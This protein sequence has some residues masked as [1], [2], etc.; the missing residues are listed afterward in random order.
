M[1]GRENVLE[2]PPHA[3]ITPARAGKS[4][5]GLKNPPS[6]GITPAR[7]GKSLCAAGVSGT[8]WDH[9]RMCGEEAVT[10]L[11]AM[12]DQ[13]SPPRMRG[14]AEFQAPCQFPVRITPAC[15][16][17][18]YTSQL[19]EANQ[20]D[21]P[22]MCGEELSPSMSMTTSRGSPPHVRGRGSPHFAARRRSRITPA[23]AGKSIAACGR[24]VTYKDH[25]RMCGEE[26]LPPNGKTWDGG[27]PP[28]VRGR[29]GDP[30]L[31]P[32]LAR[33]TPACA[34]KRPI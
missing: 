34:G 9:P 32:P 11:Y 17:K 24:V 4:V 33:I 22:R 23:C 2:T 20:G 7:A 25:P 1:R 14:R 31:V 28:H 6:I 16:G 10:M 21:H 19:I 13:G 30:V 12:A 3:G 29:E 18:R 26:D 27:S 5:R 15:A 8:R